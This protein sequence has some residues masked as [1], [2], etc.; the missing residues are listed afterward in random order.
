MMESEL[1][2]FSAGGPSVTR[3]GM[4]CWTAGGHGWGKVNDDESIA[5]IRHAFERGVTS[6]D[7]ADTYGFGKSE[8]IL[9]QALGRD[10][11]S[12]HV[13]SKGGV[14]WDESGKVW[15]DSSPEY[16]Q[17]AV[18]ASLRRLDLEQIP[19]Y[20][21]HKPDG[22]TAM[23]DA[24]GALVVLRSQ[25]KIGEIGVSNVSVSQLEEAV[26]VSPGLR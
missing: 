1:V 17:C 19:L 14:R 20:Y 24:L 2:Q 18:E 21:L 4:G 7:T 13:A 10:L 23:A 11:A 9:R 8:R 16:L 3:L 6:F 12:V 26:A 5:A 15:N 22:K 25:G